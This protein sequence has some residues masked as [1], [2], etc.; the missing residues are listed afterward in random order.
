M[1]KLFI[2]ALVCTLLASCNKNIPAN[3]NAAIRYIGDTIAVSDNSPVLK[4]LVSVTAQLQDFT[5]EFR[6]VGTVRPVTGKLAGI[7]PP[8]AGRI[9]KSFVQLGQKVNAGSPVFE[10]G[11]SEFYEATKVYFAAQSAY[12]LAQLNYNRQKE[13]A[14]NGVAAQKDLEQA[15]S[16]AHIANQEFE[17]AKATLQLF[18]IDASSLQ[19]GHPLKVLSPISGEV[20]KSDITIGNYIKEDTDPLVVVA[21]L[22]QVWVAALVKESYFG[23][24]KPG[25]HVEIFTN[26]HPNKVIWGTIYHIGEILDEE[27]RS[28]EVIVACDNA[29]RYLKLGMFCEVH[30]LSS[31]TK[32][33]ILPS[34]AIM[35]DQE[36]DYVLIELSKGHYIRRKVETE[37]VNLDSVSVVSGIS[38]GENVVVKGGIYLNR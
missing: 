14:A 38:V 3:E 22:S 18:N 13:L 15:K 36:N 27:T 6:T 5:S 11:S 23:A 32:A 35:Q 9:V 17:Q 20:V 28:L 4:D 34:T 24:I 10:L 2:L 12:E 37:S 29:D 30:F 1:K 16:E 7:A 21:D 33:I 8:F 26:A 19:M 25:D 31:P